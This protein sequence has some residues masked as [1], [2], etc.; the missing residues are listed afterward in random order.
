MG[1]IIKHYP[2]LTIVCIAHRLLTIEKFDV[3]FYLEKGSIIESG[4][5]EQLLEKNGKYKE[6]YYA[7][8][9]I[10]KNRN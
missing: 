6:L 10:N 2:D 3:I 8:K 9:K 1:N 4:N 7:Y 5:N